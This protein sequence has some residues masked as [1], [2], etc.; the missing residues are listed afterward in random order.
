M[1]I[2]TNPILTETP[3]LSST[4]VI[5]FIA[6][7]FYFNTYGANPVSRAAGRSV[8]HVI[9]KHNLQKNAL[10]IGSELLGVLKDLKANH[11]IIG[12]VR[13]EGMMMAVELVKNRDN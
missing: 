9:D 1:T 10:D 12:D 11:V 6:G 13:G 7:K 5:V 3:M 8:L 2:N 4:D